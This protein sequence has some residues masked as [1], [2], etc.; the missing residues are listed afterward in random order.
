MIHHIKYTCIY[1]GVDCVIY[2]D[3]KNINIV[4]K[5]YEKKVCTVCLRKKYKS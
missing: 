2:T 3:I 4:F 1:C 5:E